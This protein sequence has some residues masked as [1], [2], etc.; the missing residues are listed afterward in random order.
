M[1]EPPA[2]RWSRR[3]WALYW[4]FIFAVTLVWAAMSAAIAMNDRLATAA[5]VFATGAIAINW[6]VV[7]V[8]RLVRNP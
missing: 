4:L 2:P 8:V 7:V 6:F 5:I 1:T 3:Q